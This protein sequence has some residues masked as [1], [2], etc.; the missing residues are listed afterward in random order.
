LPFFV[1]ACFEPNLL[2]AFQSTGKGGHKR[3]SKEMMIRLTYK[4]GEKDM[5]EK[6]GRRYIYDNSF[7]K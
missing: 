7:V 2:K 3:R 1:K 5:W 6:E 4:R